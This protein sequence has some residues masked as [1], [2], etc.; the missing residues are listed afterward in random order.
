MEEKTVGINNYNIRDKI[1][2][3]GLLVHCVLFKSAH[4]VTWQLHLNDQKSKTTC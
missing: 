4:F 2:T 1:K 3:M